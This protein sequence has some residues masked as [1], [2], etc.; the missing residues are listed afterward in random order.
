MGKYIGLSIGVL[1]GIFV[2]I[3][4]PDFLEYLG[5]KES[6]TRLFESAKT[7]PG[8]S[9]TNSAINYLISQQKTESIITEQKLNE[10]QLQIDKM[11]QSLIIKQNGC[12]QLEL[13]RQNSGNGIQFH[14]GKDVSSIQFLDRGVKHAGFAFDGKDIYI[15]GMS[16]GINH[17]PDRTLGDKEAIDVK[18]DGNLHVNDVHF[19]R[20]GQEIWKLSQDSNGVYLTNLLTDQKY[21][22][23][24]EKI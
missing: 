15:K 22:F 19:H 2:G 9:E 6:G 13:A 11:K 20:Y 4:A 17:D 8:K 21:R 12:S 3:F 5:T 24:L 16:D 23:L 7:G 18:L 1:L 10:L 14:V